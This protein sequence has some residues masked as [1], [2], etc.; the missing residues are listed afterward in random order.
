MQTI[1]YES[2][3]P[4]DIALLLAA[5]HMGFYFTG[6]TL[7][8]LTLQTGSSIMNPA[9][10]VGEVVE[11]TYELLAVLEFNSTRKRMSVIVR[12]PWNGKIKMYTKGADSVILA[13]LGG[14]P[15]CVQYKQVRGEKCNTMYMLGL[16]IFTY[17]I[18]Y[19]RIYL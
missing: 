1:T 18:K 5:K 11:E 9:G 7:S 10:Q 19:L 8:S 4:D 2:P 16:Y 6:R 3:S 17:R 13:R 15:V 12:E 14:A